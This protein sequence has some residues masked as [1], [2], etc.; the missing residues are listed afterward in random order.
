MGDGMQLPGSFVISD[1]I[2]RYAHRGN[3][4]SD[5]APIDDL[6]DAL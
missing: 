4:S 1:G 2:V 3:L 5:T 6:L